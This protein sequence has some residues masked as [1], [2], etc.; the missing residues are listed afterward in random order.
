MKLK[1]SLLSAA[2]VV[3]LA[4]CSSTESTTQ[5]QAESV[6]QKVEKQYDNILLQK[7]AG[8]YQGVPQFDKVTLADLE[9]ALDI[10]I[11][12]NLADIDAIA[13]NPEK[14]TFENTIVA[15][16]ASGDALNRLF[17][18]YGIWANNNSSPEFRKL[19]GKLLQKFSVMSSK[20]TQNKALFERVQAVYKSDEFKSLTAEEQRITWMRYNG[21]A[22]N[23][24]TLSGD[25][26]KRYAEI[27]M[28]LSG[29]HTKFGNNVLADEENYVVYL[30]KDQ[31]AGLPKSY[32]SAAAAA[33]KARGQEGKYAVTNTRSSMDPFLKYSEE[34]ELREQV[35]NNYY[36]RGNN[37]GENN[38]RDVIS[39]ILKLRHERIQLLGYENYAQWRLEDR[40]AKAPE[41]AIELMNKVWPA[42]IAR[43]KEEVADM[44]AVADKE[45]AKIT[46]APWDYRFYAEKVRKAKYD[47]DSN[48]VKEYLQAD[49]LTEA[50]FYVAGE[51]FDFTFTPVAEGSVPVFHEDVKVWEVKRKS[52]GEHVGLFYLDPFARK[53][54]RSGAWATSFRSHTTFEG[55]TNVLS[56]NNSNFVKAP[57]G[58]A[59]LVSWDDANTYFHEFGHALHALSSNVKYPSSNGGVRDYTEFQSQLLERW[60]STDEVINKYLVHY[61]TGKPMPKSL[62][63]KIQKSS[64]FNQGFSTTEYLASAIMD[65]KFHMTDPELIGD[66]VEFEKSELSKLGMPSEIVMRHRT[67]HFGHIFSGEGYSAGYYGYLW[68]EVLTSDAAEA[69]AQSKGGFYDKDLGDRLVKYLFSVRNAMDPAEAYNKF[70]GRDAEVG[71]LMRDRGFPVSE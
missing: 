5:K 13:N 57:N 48:E 17:P 32:I 18:Y 24:A 6:V 67:T 66:P 2:V 8:P 45:G 21:F 26:A 43:V 20:I 50:M 70:R 61:K 38:N 65:M 30:T 16:E 14:P 11:A 54:K 35:W 29:L 4:A 56:T 49:K 19:Q 71:A 28:E 60:L 63:E 47:L 33:A 68:A 40:M 3:A 1:I 46:I 69:F 44:Q 41:N 64:T 52:N 27:N 9:P 15:L 59:T 62:I 22:R 36:N 55:K 53:G 37:A 51:L 42:A 12:D 23:G 58:E 7:Y 25:E 10:A 39:Q 31:L 34:R